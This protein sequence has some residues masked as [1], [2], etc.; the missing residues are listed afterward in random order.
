MNKNVLR[1][2]FSASLAK[3]TL[4]TREL[5]EISDSIMYIKPSTCNPLLKDFKKVKTKSSKGII[6]RDCFS[7]LS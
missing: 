7:I 1:G 4:E 6:C 5:F 3:L 2:S